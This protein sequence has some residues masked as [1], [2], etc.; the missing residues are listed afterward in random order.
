MTKL[1]LP[2][3]RPKYPEGDSTIGP[4]MDPPAESPESWGEEARGREQIEPRV[5][6]GQTQYSYPRQEGP[7]DNKDP[8]FRGKRGL[9]A[10][11]ED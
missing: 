1:G 4:I 3:A 6:R 2:I 10:P 9:E 7:Q 11:D 5:Q 8:D